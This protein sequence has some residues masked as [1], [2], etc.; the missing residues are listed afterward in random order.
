MCGIL[1]DVGYCKMDV[2]LTLKRKR[3]AKGRGLSSQEGGRHGFS[4]AIRLDDKLAA[5][6]EKRIPFCMRRAN[7]VVTR[8]ELELW[9]VA[10]RLEKM[11]NFHLI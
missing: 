7:E 3:R 4:D 1:S 2:E 5:D 10:F 8:A 11:K 9:F 6:A